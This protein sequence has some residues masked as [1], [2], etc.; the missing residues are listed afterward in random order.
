MSSF[1]L[2]DLFLPVSSLACSVEYCFFMFASLRIA[3]YPSDCSLFSF[4]DSF[5]PFLFIFF[6]HVVDSARLGAR[7]SLVYSSQVGALRTPIKKRELKI[8]IERYYPL[9]CS[10]QH[11]IDILS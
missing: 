7:Q 5:S 2:L 1:Y 6:L 9:L 3:V 11:R 4:Q 10:K 8:L